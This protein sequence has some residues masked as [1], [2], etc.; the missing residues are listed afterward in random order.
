MDILVLCLKTDQGR[1]GWGFTQTMSKGIFTNAA[2]WVSPLPSL[3]QIQRDFASGFWPRLQGKNPTVLKMQ[4]PNPFSAYGGMEQAIRIA[5][6]DLIAQIAELPLYQFLGGSADLNR[7]RAYASGV[8]FP[9][10]EDEA[11]KLF[12]GF[13]NR[14]FTAV[15]VKVG[16][17]DVTRDLRRLQVVRE[18]VGDAVEI[19]ADANEAWTC[20]QA[21]E[22]IR[23]FQKEGVR[24]AYV[25]DPLPRTDLEGFVHLNKAV[26]PDIVGHDYIVDNPLEV[27]RFMERGAFDRVRASTDIDEAQAYAEIAAEFG[28][29]LIVGNTVFEFC[30][31]AAVALPQSERLEFSDV[32]WNVL[33]RCPVGFENGYAIAPSQPGHGLDLDLEQLKRFSRP[34][35]EP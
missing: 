16:S 17:P 11:I 30:V 29:P 21:I 3:V 32:G 1:I 13:A 12:K 23:F 33:P 10:P 27:R 22:R 35:T 7:V 18:A 8:D 26:E 4:R 24:L 28:V 19:A 14:G 15:K 25:E 34:Q 31:H 6:W 2:P 5:L 9:L 20:E